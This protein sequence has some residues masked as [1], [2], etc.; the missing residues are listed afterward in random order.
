MKRKSNPIT[1]LTERIR[2]LVDSKDHLTPTYL[3]RSAE[4]NISQ[5]LRL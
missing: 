1:V 5:D 2:H 3:P 4:P